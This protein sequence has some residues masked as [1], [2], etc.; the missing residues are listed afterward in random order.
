ME[1]AGIPYWCCNAVA[2][3]HCAKIVIFVVVCLCVFQ[4]WAAV[5]ASNSL[6]GPTV[7]KQ[8]MFMAMF[9]WRR[10]FQQGSK[11]DEDDEDASPKLKISTK[12]IFPV[13]GDSP[14]LLLLLKGK[15]AAG[16]FQLSMVCNT[17]W[18]SVSL[19]SFES[20][21]PSIRVLALD[22]HMI[23]Y[24]KFGFELDNMDA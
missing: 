18:D 14:A 11:E 7:P 15:A 2:T 4:N 23:V 9:L 8:V 19:T 24:T 20:S 22:R 12:T 6:V 10:E 13:N 3:S 17:T 1:M 16:M 5:A 21:I